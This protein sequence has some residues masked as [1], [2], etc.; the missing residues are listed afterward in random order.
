MKLLTAFRAPLS[1]LTSGPR[2]AG[3]TGLGKSRIGMELAMREYLEYRD[4]KSSKF[5]E[6]VVDGPRQLVL[7]G[8]TPLEKGL[9]IPGQHSV[10]QRLLRHPALAGEGFVLRRDIHHTS[11]R[12]GGLDGEPAGL[13]ER[14]DGGD[15][16]AEEEPNGVLDADGRP[17]L[18]VHFDL[19]RRQAR[20]ASLPRR[21]HNPTTRNRFTV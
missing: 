19:H 9:Q 1:M 16:D 18:A 11:Y 3:Y 6:I 7:L 8:L 4:D 5:W 21:R 14:G 17:L 2:W 10:E 15:V 13:L 20:T 12:S